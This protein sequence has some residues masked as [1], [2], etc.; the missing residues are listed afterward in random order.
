M[1]GP[2]GSTHRRKAT[3][4]LLALA[5][6]SLC[7]T[8]HAQLTGRPGATGAPGPPGPIGPT[9][10]TGPTGNSGTQGDSGKRAC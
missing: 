4:F 7:S 6:A 2:L 3:A 9:G 1:G 5:L 10:P 8:T